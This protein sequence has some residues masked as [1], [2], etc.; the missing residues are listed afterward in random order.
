MQSSMCASA[1]NCVEYVTQ[2]KPQLLAAKTMY[3]AACYPFLHSK[4]SGFEWFRV[5]CCI[6][7]TN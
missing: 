7:C 2:V 1:L 5:V 6:Q 4:T 3:F